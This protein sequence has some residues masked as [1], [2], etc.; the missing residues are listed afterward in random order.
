[1]RLQYGVRR[2][3][4]SSTFE[5]VAASV[6]TRSVGSVDHGFFWGLGGSHCEDRKSVAFFFYQYELCLMHTACTV[7]KALLLDVSTGSQ[8]NDVFLGVLGE[9]AFIN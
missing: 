5:L 2:C 1:M 7:S 9:K 4:E 6:S 3:F 8:M